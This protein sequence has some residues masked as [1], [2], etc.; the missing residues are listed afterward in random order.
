[1]KLSQMTSQE[2]QQKMDPNGNPEKIIALMSEIYGL[3]TQKADINN[4]AE[5]FN[6]ELALKRLQAE[7][8]VWIRIIESR[9][10]KKYINSK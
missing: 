6:V 8:R 5:M 1:M 9:T 3:I 10:G 2:V 4:P 7:G